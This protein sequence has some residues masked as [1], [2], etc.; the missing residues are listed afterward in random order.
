MAIT[1][2]V[3][4][5]AAEGSS[6]TLTAPS[7]SVFTSVEFASYGTPNGNCGGF[8][9]GTCH[10][11]ISQ[12]VVE[13]YL[14][15]QSGSITI[16]ASNG[17]FTDPCAGTYKRL[18]VQATATDAGATTAITFTAGSAGNWTVP[19]GIYSITLT[20]IG[21]GGNGNANTDYTPG[22]G[23]GSG[24][25][26]SSVTV[27]VTPGQAIAYSVGRGGY[28]TA[29]NPYQ[30]DG[31]AS[32]FGSLIAGGGQGGH[33]R[34]THTPNPSDE[35]PGSGGVATGTGGVNGTDGT[36]GGRY[37]GNGYGAS[38][39]F[40]T[41]GAGTGG[42]GGAATGFGAGGGG[43]GNNSGQGQGAD[44][45]ITIGYDIIL[46]VINID[47][48]NIAAT[49]L[50][51]VYEYQSF[52]ST[53]YFTTS[54]SIYGYR[55]A[56]A[57][58]TDQLKVAYNTY[59]SVLTADSTITVTTQY[60]T[61]SGYHKR[62]FRDEHWK[63]RRTHD[64]ATEYE[65]LRYENLP[66]SYFS[67]W[68]YQ[69]DLR[70]STSVGIVFYTDRGEIGLTGTVLN[71]WSAN[72]NRLKS[73]I[74]ASTV[75]A[76][77]YSR[78]P[79]Q[80]SYATQTSVATVA[81]NTSVSLLSGTGTF[82]VPAYVT[83]V[84]VTY[85]TTGGTVTTSIVVTPGTSLTY[86]IGAAGTGSTIG[87]ITT[88]N[89]SQ[90]VC[91]WSGN[92]DA[93]MRHS[94]TAVTSGNLTYTGSG[95][96]STL[97]SGATSAGLY[98]NVDSES[99]HGDL[100]AN[101]NLTPANPAY[102]NYDTSLTISTSAFSGREQSYSVVTQ[103]RASNYYIAQ[104]QATDGNYSEGSYSWTVVLQ[105]AILLTVSWV[106]PDPTK[107]L[108]NY[109]YQA[110]ANNTNIISAY[111]Y[112]PQQG[113]LQNG[114]GSCLAGGDPSYAT[115]INGGW[116]A[117]DP[118]YP[119][120]YQNNGLACQY[121]GVT[122]D[123][124]ST[125]SIAYVRN[126]VASGAAAAAFTSVS[127]VGSV[128]GGSSFTAILRSGY[129]CY[130]QNNSGTYC[131][132]NSGREIT[133]YMNSTSTGINY[134]TAG[135]GTDS[136]ILCIFTE[137]GCIWRNDSNT[138][139]T[140]DITMNA[141]G[142]GK[143]GS[144]R[145]S[146]DGVVVSTTNHGDTGCSGKNYGNEVVGPFNITSSSC[147]LVE[148]Y[149]WGC[150][151]FQYGVNYITGGSYQV[152]A[153]KVI[154][155]VITAP[156][157]GSSGGTYVTGSTSFS[158]AGST[159]NWTVPAGVYSLGVTIAGAGGGGGGADGGGT[160]GAGLGGAVLT[161]SLSVTPGQ[162]YTL[163]LGSG[164]GGGAGGVAGTGGGTAGTGGS[165]GTTY[166]VCGTAAENGTVSLTAPPGTTFTSVDFASYGTP[167]GSCGSFAL[168]GCHASNSVSVVQGY[169]IGNGG[170]INIPA[171]NATF[172]DPCSG[173]PKSLYVQATASAG[174][175]SYA[176]GTGGNAGPSGTSGGGGG[177]GGASYMSL[178][179]TAVLVAGGGGGGGGAGNSG[180]ATT[181]VS[182]YNSTT[183]GADGGSHGSDGGGGGA[184]GGGAP[185]GGAG[186]VAPA[187]DNSGS[188]GNTGQS[189]YPGGF[190]TGTATNGGAANTGAGSGG[191]IT[192]SW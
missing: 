62:N 119:T 83:N 57:G 31:T 48:D 104:D 70:T 85:M 175:A 130:T 150:G 156:G 46:Q 167:S 122:I 105:Q 12:S 38:S 33:W 42:A 44:G 89:W 172:G 92:I 138:S 190:S 91:T 111:S 17:V 123:P 171:N 140:I 32:V 36:A 126:L 96:N 113:G 142:Q 67:L 187:G 30:Y 22:A 86:S 170:T 4:G 63:Y 51:T 145:V 121:W 66:S 34:G 173:T 147:V 21:G 178:S 56:G 69:P 78:L 127:Q 128:A 116:R 124:G 50:P 26:F 177:G 28:S 146:I 60:V 40:G 41:G 155:A 103:P 45:F 68:Q 151:N 164:G 125:S 120:S 106:T 98:Y 134:G 152:N 112:V 25:Y 24:A 110:Q 77:D 176:G 143:L 14:L 148:Q 5:V 3:C 81:Y 58:D 37:G 55:W 29:N 165:A 94:W 133:F 71:D 27:N 11:S 168:G 185:Y 158:V 183:T 10:A 191:Y 35:L 174:V 19:A 39:P 72:R 181:P 154:T 101:L 23:G 102:I 108:Y 169:L 84:W 163:G 7:G 18:Y 109:Q 160:P 76:T 6:A 179:N 99:A 43:G 118:Y 161:G 90:Q 75:N 8:S 93:I 132:M 80:L 73:L 1:Y 139:G 157:S 47:T 144:W 184:G 117:G 59:N 162:V 65:I 129:Y 95:G 100:G 141:V 16:P 52:Y 61:I 74:D 15:G 137:G 192:L 136:T 82:T 54:V 13:G 159:Q 79:Q 115:D 88:P 114:G 149:W 97:Q 186:G 180:G 189:T 49:M 153:D 131:L 2:R 166:Q 87:T 64:D 188:G 107:V 53:H 9:L 20:M 135:R 182:T